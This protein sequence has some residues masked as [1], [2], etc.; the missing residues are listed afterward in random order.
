M[1]WRSFASSLL[2][3]ACALTGAQAGA[4]GPDRQ[5]LL[6][7]WT[8]EYVCNQGVTG[9]TLRIDRVEPDIRARYIFYRIDE[10]PNLPSGCFTLRGAYD[11]ASGALK[12]FQFEWIRQPEGWLMVDLDGVVDPLGPAFAGAVFGYNCT[13]FT[14]QKAAEPTDADDL[15][16]GDALYSQRAR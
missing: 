5:D 15:C 12:L 3:V 16:Y 11:P 7:D 14:L 9:M 13:T 6:G 2:A 4:Q 8:G 1:R 10:N